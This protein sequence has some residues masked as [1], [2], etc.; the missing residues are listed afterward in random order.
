MNL[1]YAQL[2]SADYGLGPMRLTT[3]STSIDDW[4]REDLMS[5]IYRIGIM[6]VSVI[7]S[8]FLI[9]TNVRLAIQSPALYSYGFSKYDIPSHAGIELPE[10]ISVGRQI[11]EYFNDEEEFLNVTINRFGTP[12]PNL[13]NSR[14][15]LHMKD[16][17]FLVQGTYRLQEL[18]GLLIAL[19]TIYG[20]ITGKRVFF[21]RLGIYCLC[22]GLT[23]LAVISLAG[24]IS[25]VGFEQAFVIFHKISFTNDLWQLNPHTDMLLIMFPQGFFFDTT[26]LIAALTVVESI[27]LIIG[28]K[29]IMIAF[30]D[31]T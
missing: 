10:L 27:V 18:S 31:N 14:E 21:S 16:V 22:A 29:L 12:V 26:M 6:I 17:K 30:R 20:L 8:F 24:I 3:L 23:T 25:L 2:D 15:I 13:Y 5:I 7:I 1:V 28:S 4:N 11:R 19:F 9:S